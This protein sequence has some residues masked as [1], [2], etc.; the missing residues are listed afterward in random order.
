MHIKEWAASRIAVTK[1][2]GLYHLNGM[3]EARSNN[4]NIYK[5][6]Y[7]ACDYDYVRAYEKSV[8]EMCERA[9]WLSLYCEY[10][11]IFSETV[12]FSAHVDKDCAILNAKREYI[13]RKILQVFMELIVKDYNR[14]TD[15]FDINID[16]EGIKA[17]FS[18]ENTE[19]LIFF[20]NSI[21]HGNQGMVIGMG[22]GN[23]REESE[24][25]GHSEAMLVERALNRKW[26][27]KTKDSVTDIA[28][29]KTLFF[30]RALLGC[31]KSL[32]KGYYES[33]GNSIDISN[34]S[35]NLSSYL[36]DFLEKFNR[37]VFYSCDK[38]KMCLIHEIIT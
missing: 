1:R 5:I 37:V 16:D 30:N 13:E 6:P 21:V 33:R 36:P 18:D 29:Y 11:R 28:F 23:T 31:F 3:I 17:W 19:F 8:S 25:Q 2:N 34:D 9:T 4:G 27:I 24:I 35:I 15:Y 32:E 10:P 20:K 26:N 12:G 7:G 38:E 14:L 22:K